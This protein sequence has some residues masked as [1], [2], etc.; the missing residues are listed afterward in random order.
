MINQR[1]I[2][3]LSS[4]ICV[5]AVS[6]AVFSSSL[7]FAATKMKPQP[8]KPVK[9]VGM[10]KFVLKGTVLSTSANTLT[11]HV[12][13]TS[14]NARIFDGKDR[15]LSVAKRT[16]IT[17]NG[18]NTTLKQ[19]KAGDKVKVFGIFNKKSGSVTLV[20]WVKVVSK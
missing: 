5:F 9:V 17:K 18:K 16:T 6:M 7:A 8:A 14:K 13:N 1:K 11:I 3:A 10:A 4:T 2:S 12:T 19:I 15:A 20:R